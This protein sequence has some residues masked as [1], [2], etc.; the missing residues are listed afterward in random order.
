L[1]QIGKRNLTIIGVAG[2]VLVL[3]VFLALAAGR[4]GAFTGIQGEEPVTTAPP[5]PTPSPTVA[6]TTEIDPTHT[7]TSVSVL[8][9]AEPTIEPT[10]TPDLEGELNQDGTLWAPYLEWALQ[11]P[12]YTGN[13]F[14]LTAWVIFEHR[15]SGELR[16]TQMF[17]AG[18]DTW[19]FRFTGTRTG[20]WFFRTESQEAPLLDGHSGKVTIHPNSDPEIRGFLVNYGN[21]FAR[22]IGEDGQLEAFIFN[23]WQGGDYPNDVV[24]WYY[25]PDI[26]THIDYGIENYVRAHGM[27][28][29]YSNVIGN[30]WFNLE[31]QTWDEHDSENPD[32]RMFEGL[33]KA[34]SYLHSK[35]LH[36]H[37]WKWGDE[38][39]RQTPIGVGGI[40]GEADRRLQRYIAARLG[41]LPGWSMGYGFDLGDPNWVRGDEDKLESWAIYMQRY[42]GWPHLL[43]ARGYAPPSISGVSYSSNG[44]GS[45]T[46]AIQTSPNGPMTYEEVVR[47]IESDLTRP[48]LYEERF[49]YLR[50]F[51]GGPR[52]TDERTRRVM[53]WNTMAGGI[54]AF[55][56]VWDG[57]LY[58]H[59]EAMRTHYQFWKD[60]FLLDMERANYLTDGYALI[61][62]DRE[63]LV[64]YKENATFITMDLRYSPPELT[65]FAVDTTQGYN[66][67]PL[68]KL[69]PGVHRWEA[70]YQSDWAVAV[71]FE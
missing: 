41:P 69:E 56:G 35:G 21:K 68:G 33:E 22:Q 49:I 45:P 62:P 28:V 54:G 26:Y 70:P 30:R 50:E 8:P 64:F 14:D 13:P 46:G 31:T 58:T 36:L 16:R 48:H 57:P 11:N 20:E 27:T 40:N 59:P 52:W 5:V 42:M 38:N 25:D 55:W 53:W 1:S 19:K 51:E 2:A 47:H 44:P 67:I 12:G 60:R 39:R 7:A 15:H 29:V 34:I 17:Y 71:G 61:T 4:T 65:A 9:T 6:A 66:E 24:A 3:L 10:P 23:V 43:F 37:I 32:L 18:D 63:N